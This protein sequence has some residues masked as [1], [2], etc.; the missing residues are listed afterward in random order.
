MEDAV[1]HDE[2]IHMHRVSSKWNWQTVQKCVSII[3]SL[4]PDL[5]DIVFTGWMYNDH[6]SITFLPTL[7]KQS[8]PGVRVVVH[9][10][11]L[12]G[13][14]RDKSN[15]ARA[16]S[17]YAASLVTGRKNISYEYGTLLR[18][19]DAVITFGERD[20]A[21]LIK[22]NAEVATKSATISP[23]PIMPVSITLSEKERR[24][25]RARLGL[26]SDSDLLLGFYGYIYPGK[27]IETLFEASKY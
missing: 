19:A 8:C 27:G 18:D 21:E 22:H 26:N 24:S 12:G 16:V 6:P 5:V 20:R 4:Q 14:R 3:K 23:P 13:I 9:I 10:E 25:E 1:A 11:S 2:R 15:F 7:V 17:R